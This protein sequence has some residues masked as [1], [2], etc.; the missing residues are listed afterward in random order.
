MVFLGLKVNGSDICDQWARG[1]K[2]NEALYINDKKVCQTERERQ[3]PREEQMSGAAWVFLPAG[4]V[5]SGR[6]V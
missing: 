5:S 6:Q 2:I 1:R 4:T 3:T